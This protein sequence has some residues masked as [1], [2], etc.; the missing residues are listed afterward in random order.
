QPGAWR[1][2]YM[3]EI[4]IRLKL[5]E[6]DAR[7]IPDLS[8]SADIG[9]ASEKQATVAPLHAVFREGSATPFVFLRTRSGWQRREIELGLANHVVAVVR[10]GLKQGDIVAAERPDTAK[11]PS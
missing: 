4:P 10:S 5:D 11:P 7:V 6:M 2:S 1:P 3:R 8:A 9:V